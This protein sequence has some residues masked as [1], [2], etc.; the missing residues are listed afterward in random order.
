MATDL[1]TTLQNLTAL[2]ATD[3]P[4]LSV[5]LDW[6]PDGQGNRQALLNLDQDF[7]RIEARLK[8]ED[9]SHEQ[10]NGF[11][12]DRDRIKEY[13]DREA[14]VDAKGLAIFACSGEGF[15]E[16]V[17]LQVAVESEIAADRYPHTFNL[18]RI[19]DDYETYAV[20][21][22]DSEE[23]RIL[24]VSL[25]EAEQVA[26]TESADEVRRFEAGGWAQMLLQ[27]RM[28][29]IV[30]AHTKEIADTLSR[31]VKRYGVQHVIVASNDTIKGTIRS[32]LPDNLKEMLVDHIN[33]DMTGSLASILETTE[34]MM[35]EVERNQEQ[36]DLQTLQDQVGA[37]GLGI[38]GVSETALALTK[39]Q[40]QT[41]IILKDFAGTGG[42]CPNC[43]TLRAGMRPTCPYDGAEMNQ[44]DL[45]EAF[46]QRAAQS[47]ATIQV[48]EASE[49]L[50]QNGGVGGL[51]RYRDTPQ[52]QTV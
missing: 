39:G 15:W 35:R 40:V 10:L 30:K 46:T 33:L 9:R 27:R 50:E 49:Y 24:V 22:A 42:E 32:S 43:G 13:L 4:F 11:Y 6:T 31:V 47:G 12:A 37:Q 7:E 1:E 14:P 44:L 20:V 25:N 45:R 52:A 34:P 41:L 16:V 23:S 5:Y 26:Q 17:P 51:L 36:S 18:A 2:P 38:V 8:A 48:V 3:H 21:L 28:Q 29:N 19:I